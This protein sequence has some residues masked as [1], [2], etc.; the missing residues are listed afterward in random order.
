MHVSWA[1]YVNEFLDGLPCTRLRCA[2]READT[3]RA[4]G[5]SGFYVALLVS[6]GA[7]LI[8]RRSLLIFALVATVCGLSFYAYAYVRRWITGRE[9]IVLLEHVWFAFACVSLT[10][11]VL[12]QPILPYLDIVSVGL[13]FFLAAGRI[14]C[15]LVGCCHG[16]PSS[17]GIAY[18]ETCTRDGFPHY[19][20]GVRLFPVPAIEAAG[21]LIIGLTGLIALP[22]AYPGEI[23]AW[24]LLAYSVMRFGLEGL[25]GDPRPHLLG[26]SQARW[27]SLVEVAAVLWWSDAR[28]PSASRIVMAVAVLLLLV[29]GLS[30]KW[31]LDPR[32]RILSESHV[33]ELRTA[34]T[35]ELPTHPVIHVSSCG[36]K[37]AASKT[38]GGFGTEAHVSLSLPGDRSDIQLLCELGARAFPDSS[39]NAA[40][41][42]RGT[43]LHLLT[44]TPPNLTQ[45]DERFLVEHGRA[46]YG[47]VVR[48]MQREK[49]AV[50]VVPPAAAVAKTETAPVPVVGPAIVPPAPRRRPW[51]FTVPK[52]DQG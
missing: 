16:H 34:V 46:L 42:G 11:W 49:A 32:R 29:A 21:L 45:A 39:A 3:Y 23:F 51:Y 25:R 2:G 15:T 17:I 18:N 38:G 31:A 22:S 6:T 48:R 19:L 37:I 4:C 7:T 20:V 27:M 36:V 50:P 12:R 52:P 30:L 47:A 40:Y 44:T 35:T 10:L 8:T 13:C 14:G 28:A 1:S 5:I 41:V 43:L 9:T 26:L 33:S 24:Y